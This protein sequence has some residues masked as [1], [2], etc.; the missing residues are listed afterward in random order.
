[1]TTTGQRPLDGQARRITPA[2]LVRRFF[3][4]RGGA[5]AIEFVILALP[6]SALIFAILESCVSFAAQQLISN[7]TDD[8][9]RQIRTGQV[10]AADI[11]ETKIRTM[12]CDRISLVV[13]D[14]CPGLEID[15]REYTSFEDA[16]K[17]SFKI[18]SGEIKLTKNGASDGD[19]KIEPGK[20]LTKNM[21]RVFY[22]WPVMTDYL[23]KSM[24]NLKDDKTLLYATT[25]WQNEPFDD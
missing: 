3:R 9:A 10:K 11:T 14:D 22:R 23:R 20:S 17:A 12:V 7:A 6:F 4:A 18:E 21:L 13:G 1:M 15:L 5:T 19:F 16:A 25:T 2:G 8:I 24:A